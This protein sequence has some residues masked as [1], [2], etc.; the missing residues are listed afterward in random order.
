MYLHDCGTK[1][2]L[3]TACH[4][5]APRDLHLSLPASLP[6]HYTRIELPASRRPL[7]DN[8]Y[9]RC[10]MSAADQKAYI[11]LGYLNMEGE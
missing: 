2:G 11:K 1:Y 6:E 5:Y 3:G 9:F 7:E 10:R 4:V 8:V